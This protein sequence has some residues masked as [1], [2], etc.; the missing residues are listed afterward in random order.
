VDYVVYGTGYGATLMLLGYALRTWGSKWRF[1]NQDENAY[2]LQEFRSAR[3]AWTRFTSGLGAVIATCGAVLVLFTFLLMLFN[4]GDDVGVLVA[5]IVSGAVLIAVAVSAWFYFDRYGTWGILSTPDPLS[6]YS[7]MQYGTSVRPVAAVNASSIATVPEYDQDEDPES[8]ATSEDEEADSDELYVDDDAEARYA[9]Y[10]SHHPDGRT[11]VGTESDEATDHDADVDSETEEGGTVAS[12]SEP[13]ESEA[14]PEIVAVDGEPQT[15]DESSEDQAD[16]L[17]STES[18]AEQ[19]SAASGTS[20]SDDAVSDS[21]EETVEI[22]VPETVAVADADNDEPAPDVIVE[23]HEPASESLPEDDLL[24]PEPRVSEP[25]GRE[26]ALR[27]LRERRA[28]RN[29]SGADD[30]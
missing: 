15:T 9:K 25:G 4:P 18:V 17:T 2:D 20:T 29:Q 7:P 10:I 27:R 28:Q 14:A 30:A 22:E 8:S 12:D 13:A 11:T 19:G 3:S 26:D 16:D 6:S 1:A 23:A 21:S 5:L 24:V